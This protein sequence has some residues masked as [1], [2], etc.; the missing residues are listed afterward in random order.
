[1]HIAERAHGKVGPF[2]ENVAGALAYLTFIPAVVFLVRAPYN[3]DRFARFHSVQCLLFWLVSIS[4]AAAIR[5]A[6]LILILVPIVGPLIVTLVSVVTA[7]AL[8]VIW[9]VLAVKALQGEMFKLP[10]L[11]ELADRYADPL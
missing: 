1:M 11:G 2:P 9:A 6:A 5:L 4:L 8:V 3:R 10:L 7:L